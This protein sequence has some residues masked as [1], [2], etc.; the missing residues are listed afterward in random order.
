MPPR[1]APV[2]SRSRL[3]RRYATS[4]VPA[5]VVT[6][7]AVYF[8]L[9][10]VDFG[11][12][13]DALASS[14]YATL[15]PALAL[16]ALAVYLRVLRWQFLFPAATRPSVRPTTEALLIGQFFN[17]VLPARAGE[18]FRMLALHARAR[19]SRAETLATIIVERAFDLL[20]LLV[21]FFVALPWLPAV[22]W[23]RV[24]GLLAAG[25][26]LALAAVIIVL[27]RYGVRPVRLLV[28]PLSR[29][30]FVSVK[31][32]DLGA[33]SVVRGFAALR[34]VR[35]G[36]AAFGLTVAS[37][38]TLSA[39]F[40]FVAIG[41][42]RD[43][44]PSAGLLLAVATGLALVLPSG[45]AGVGVFEAAA[46]VALGAYGL[47]RSEALSAALVLHAVNFFPFIVAGAA[48]LLFWGGARRPWALRWFAPD[49]P[50]REPEREIEAIESA[51]ERHEP[52]IGGE[53]PARDV[54]ATEKAA[55]HEPTDRA[56]GVHV[57]DVL[58]D[59]AAAFE[60]PGERPLS[61][62][63]FVPDGPIGGTEQPRM[64]GDEQ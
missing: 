31:R 32:V 13:K 56:D 39:S 33:A 36:A 15:G 11:T 45:P 22:S 53:W 34:D 19:T 9:R 57:P 21:L 44:P 10:G 51:Q 29:L 46:V 14:N 26:S 23:V 7:A 4:L 12:V 40:W 50:Q 6:A 62:A 35:L 54:G 43:L 64:R 55:R 61:V 2:K 30:P 49:R 41:F 28:L 59:E 1:M 27:A 24:A 47:S 63:P 16:L 17:N 37:W 25:L 60:E 8:A 18:V 42:H 48:V 5:V 38:L 3:G 20:A 58:D 52:V